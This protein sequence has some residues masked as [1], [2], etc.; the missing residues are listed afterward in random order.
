MAKTYSQKVKNVVAKITTII[1]GGPEYYTIYYDYIDEIINK[2][3]FSIF[4]DALYSA[5]KI[6]IVNYIDVTTLKSRTF[7]QIRMFTYSKTQQQLKSLLDKNGLY[8]TSFNIFNSSDNNFLGTIREVNKL[9]YTYQFYKD[10]DLRA[11]Q[12]DPINVYLAITKNNTSYPHGNTWSLYFNDEYQLFWNTKLGPTNST[13]LY[14]NIS[15]NGN[16]IS[17]L[18]YS[19]VSPIP[20]Q[21][22]NI[23]PSY[24]IATYSTYIS[25]TSSNIR[26]NDI[27]LEY[28][29]TNIDDGTPIINKYTQAITYLKS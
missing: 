8:Q 7:N 15:V 24:G 14:N 29:I 17:S 18:T 6:R 11:I 12:D 2:G 13:Y 27:Q 22:P 1:S 25:F 26:S 10:P 3:E 21:L 23:L 20:T 19:L 5:W 28:K 16:L 4:E 9:Q